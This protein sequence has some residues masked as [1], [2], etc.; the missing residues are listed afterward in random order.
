MFMWECWWVEAYKV[1]KGMDGVNTVGGGAENSG[2][3]TQAKKEKKN[4]TC[5]YKYDH[6]LC[7]NN[8]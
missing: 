4:K 5:I 3:G 8:E 6:F 1:V 2:T 7:T